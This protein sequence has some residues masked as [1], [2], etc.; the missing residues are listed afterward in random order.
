MTPRNRA[1]Q[2]LTGPMI[3]ALL[4]AGAVLS[5]TPEL[6]AEEAVCGGWSNGQ[7]VAQINEERL[8]E[9]SGLAAGW[10]NPDVLWTHNDSGDSARLFAL[11]TAPSADSDASPILTEL[12]LEGAENVDWEDM[13]IGPCAADSDTACI[14]VADFGDNL[15]QRDEVVIY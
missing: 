14:Y 10:K 11:S 2:G 12:T 6:R 9:S 8:A 1:R 15:K 13:A 5:G 7:Q 3:T 4:T